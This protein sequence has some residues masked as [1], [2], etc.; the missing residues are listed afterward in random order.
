M[1]PEKVTTMCRIVT[2][3]SFKNNGNGPSPKTNWPKG[4]N[5]LKYMYGVFL[6]LRLYPV[7][8][9]FDL[10]KMFHS[11]RTGNTEL[12]KRLMVWRNG[13]L[14]T[15]W[16]TYGW[17]VVN[18]GDRPASCI[19]EICKDLAADAGQ[20]INPEAATAIREDTYIDDWRHNRG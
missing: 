3:S 2:N 16:T 6:R 8:V 9:H 19:L 1:T 14:D 5:A 10:K 11:V 12:F 4:P 17:T 13:V 7:S 15:K 20:H 18:F